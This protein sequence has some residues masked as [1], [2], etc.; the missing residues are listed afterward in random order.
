MDEET[1]RYI[2]GNTPVTD[3]EEIDQSD[4]FCLKRWCQGQTRGDKVYIVVTEL[5][6]SI[7]TTIR[8]IRAEQLKQEQKYKKEEEKRA[9]AKAKR[10]A[11]REANKLKKL[12][13]NKELLAQ[14]KE[15]IGENT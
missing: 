10:D 11:K 4:L 3:W 1:F 2:L 8:E 15:H 7:N 5:E 6:V 12:L 13:N 14:L 9:Q